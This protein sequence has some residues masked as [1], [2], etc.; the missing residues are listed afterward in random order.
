[1]RRMTPS[2]ALIALLCISPLALG[3]DESKSL[4]DLIKQIEDQ[5]EKYAR[6]K[7]L[8]VDPDESKRVAAFQ[9]MTSSDNQE[10]RNVAIE[11]ALV[12]GD[13]VLRS[14]ALSTIILTRSTLTLRL[15]AYDENSE[16]QQKAL[17]NYGTLV[18]VSLGNW[19]HSTGYFTTIVSGR[20]GS[21]QV[22]GDVVSFGRS[23]SGI[24]QPYAASLQLNSQGVLEGFFTY[25]SRE[26]VKAE[27]LLR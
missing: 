13:K 7:A 11:H 21:G 4:D 5:S 19:A 17:E 20:E 3:Q 26:K 14:L 8:L 15:S 6:F 1:M 12:S 24:N 25:G 9:A 23:V 16:A 22:T 27:I 10:L 2:I 18:S